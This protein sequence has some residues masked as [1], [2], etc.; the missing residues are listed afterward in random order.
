MQLLVVTK[1]NE[2]FAAQLRGLRLLLGR[3]NKPIS[4]E[5]FAEM[6]GIALGTVRTIENGSRKLSDEDRQ[7]IAHHLRAHWSPQKKRWVDVRDG[8]TPYSRQLYETHAQAL[9]AKTTPEMRKGTFI[10]TTLPALFYLL[11]K[12]P[13]RSY[14]L[15]ILKIHDCLQAI[16]ETSDAPPE[17]FEVLKLCAPAVKTADEIPGSIPRPEE[18]FSYMYSTYPKDYLRLKKPDLLDNM[19]W[20]IIK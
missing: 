2:N 1:Q 18:P 19:L 20:E 7:K 12:L 13:D 3:D 16:A 6:S 9:N 11:M 10:F 4:G 15:A 8:K 17:V 14:R 5:T